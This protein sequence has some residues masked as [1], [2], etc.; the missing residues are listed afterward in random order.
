MHVNVKEISEKRNFLKSRLRTK[1]VKLIL[2]FLQFTTHFLPVL[3][4]ISQEFNL[5]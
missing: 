1:K 4:L 2:I 3:E 5:I